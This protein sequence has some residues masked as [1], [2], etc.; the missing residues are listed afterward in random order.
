MEGI[1]QDMTMNVTSVA[2]LEKTTLGCYGRPTP[3][4]LN[5]H[6]EF[7]FCQWHESEPRPPLNT[8]RCHFLC[9][10]SRTHARGK[11]A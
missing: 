8:N 4:R 2:L 11:Q 1:Q 7:L 6:E 3:P 5:Y 9:C 10:K